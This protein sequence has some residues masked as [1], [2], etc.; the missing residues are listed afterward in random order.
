MWHAQFTMVL[1]K[2]FSD[3]K[4]ASQK[5]QSFL[6][7]KY[8]VLTRISIYFSRNTHRPINRGGGGYW[9]LYPPPPTGSVKS[10]CFRGFWGPNWCC[11]WTNSWI[12]PWKSHYKETTIENNQFTKL[13][14]W[15]SSLCFCE[16]DV[17]FYNES[18][19]DIRYFCPLK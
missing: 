9:S 5:H 7:S 3:Q 10:M 17:A 1:L 8:N 6:A 11:C 19:L 2:P 16:S 18:S 4:C 14:T 13:K 12:R 15:I